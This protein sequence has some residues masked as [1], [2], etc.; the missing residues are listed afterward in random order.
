MPKNKTLRAILAENVAGTM[1]AKKLKQQ[2]VAN[3]AK[4]RGTPINQTSV[5]RVARGVYPANVDTIE[6]MANGLGLESWQLLMSG[7]ADKNFLAILRAWSV[8]STRGR[9]LLLFA[10]EAAMKDD[11]EQQRS[12]GNSS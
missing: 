4:K 2:E 5:G 11:E 1:L 12:R 8:S 3:V 7:A 10:A 9:K 6:A